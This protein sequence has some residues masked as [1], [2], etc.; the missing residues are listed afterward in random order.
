VTERTQIAT[1]V[2]DVQVLDR[3]LPETAHDFRVDLIATPTRVLRCPRAPRPNGLIWE[4]LDADKIAAIP[5]LAARRALRS[6]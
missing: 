2:H 1:T 3:L 5:A 6:R 4:H